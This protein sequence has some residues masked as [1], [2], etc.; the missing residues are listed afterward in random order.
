MQSEDTG[1][2]P[3]FDVQHIGALLAEEPPQQQPPQVSGRGLMGCRG[4]HESGTGTSGAEISRQT[5]RLCLRA[6]PDVDE[7]RKSGGGPSQDPEGAGPSSGPSP[8]SSGRARNYNRP[9]PTLNPKVWA[10]LPSFALSGR[11]AFPS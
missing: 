3:D 2:Q 9:F 11:G 5:K 7:A 1:G 4:R 6:N 10:S 8:L